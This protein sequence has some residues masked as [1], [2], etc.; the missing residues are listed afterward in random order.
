MMKVH[1]CAGRAAGGHASA[2]RAPTGVSMAG[3]ALWIDVNNPDRNDVDIIKRE[4]GLD[5]PT[6]A[7]LSEVENSSRLRSVDKALYLSL[8]LVTLTDGHVRTIPLGFIVTA[9]RLVTIRFD[10]VPS[11]AA[12]EKLLE[13][14]GIA[15]PSAPGAFAALIEGIVGRLA[16]ALEEIGA[17]VDTIVEAVFGSADVEPNARD[18]KGQDA[19]L[20]ATLKQVGRERQFVSKIRAT[21]LGVGRIIPYVDGEGEEWLSDATKSRLE[22]ARQDIESLDQFEEHLS[23]KIQFLL[24]AATTS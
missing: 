19:K 23:G 5:L 1:S 17:R 15:H 20:R 13:A 4:T 7:Q 8:P 2:G 16:D 18:K 9:E 14:G 6:R 11:F 10:D 21:L 3:D 12:V 22:S 24:D